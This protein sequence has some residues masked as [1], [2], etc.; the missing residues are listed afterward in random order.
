MWRSKSSAGLT[1]LRRHHH[2]C[3]LIARLTSIRHRSSSTDSVKRRPSFRLVRCLRSTQ[4]RRSLLFE[5]F[6]SVLGD[7]E[8][9]SV[10]SNRVSSNKIWILK[11]RGQRLAC[12][13]RRMPPE[14]QEFR[15]QRLRNVPL[16]RGN[17]AR[18]SLRRTCPTE[19]GLAGWGAWIRTRGWRDQNPTNSFEVSKRILKF[20]PKLP[21]AAS[22]ASQCVQ[23][24]KASPCS[25][26]CRGPALKNRAKLCAMFPR[27]LIE[28][29]RFGEY[30]RRLA[31]L[32]GIFWACP[33]RVI[34]ASRVFWTISENGQR[35]I[36]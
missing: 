3:Q 20:R 23:N 6:S 22:K 35:E 17:V 31:P 1:A 10:R 26:N 9:V 15:P 32:F 28:P 29:H 7:I 13:I 34:H 25:A 14:F 33:T 19:T 5:H 30:R 2:A 18:I 21:V 12:E 24:G 11:N 36:N 4:E 16:T 8:L 27:P